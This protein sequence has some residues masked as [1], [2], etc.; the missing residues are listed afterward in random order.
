[1][2]AAIVRLRLFLDNNVPDSV[3]RYLQGRGHSVKR[4]RFWISADSPD[5]VVATT[6][7]ESDR[8]LV[9]LDR[10]F[11]SQRFQQ[12]RFARLCRI[13]LSGPAHELIDAIKEYIHL[14]ERQWEHCQR[15]RAPRMIVHLKP[16]QIR[17][18]A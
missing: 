12:D 8:I 2:P 11:N 16:G 3:G 9:T 4:L 7:M 13:S 10:D 6:A 15:T 5:P 17:I 1:M 18:R 14:I